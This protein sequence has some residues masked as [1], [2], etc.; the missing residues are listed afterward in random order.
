MAVVVFFAAVPITL[1]T[2]WFGANGQEMKQY[3]TCL[4]LNL[5]VQQPIEKGCAVFLPH[6]RDNFILG[7]IAA[8]ACSY[9]LQLAYYR[10]ML[11]VALGAPRAD[12]KV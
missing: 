6:S 8:V 7:L 2:V 3:E 12:S 5:A 4:Q 11:Y 1:F 10:V 9:L